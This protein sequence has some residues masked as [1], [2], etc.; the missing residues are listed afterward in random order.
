MLEYVE[1]LRVPSKSDMTYNLWVVA[2]P[3]NKISCSANI[4]C[5]P[6]FVLQPRAKEATFIVLNTKAV[7][8]RATHL[9]G[10]ARTV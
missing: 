1:S 5:A 9:F 4:N 6:P 10:V 2:R 7:F 3:C 8:M